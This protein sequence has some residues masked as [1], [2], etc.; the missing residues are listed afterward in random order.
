M[1]NL[2][3]TLR[4]GTIFMMQKQKGFTLLELVVV[5]VLI[6]IVS[7]AAAPSFQRWRQQQRFETDTQ[8]VLL[9]L[10]DARADSLSDKMCDGGTATAWNVLIN[11]TQITY[12]CAQVDGNSVVISVLP[13]T[14][15]AILTSQESENRTT[16]SAAGS[17]QISVFS[18]GMN[19][20][21]GSTYQ[22]QW[23]K[24]SLASSA[25]GK[26]QTVCYS[27]IANYPFLSPSGL[28]TED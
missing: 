10:A 8:N 15:D 19:A 9:A 7:G 27:R 16:W 6:G 22:S 26:E 12:G 4:T 25:L 17:L 21:I 3:P 23:A 2:P 20:R 24:V 1:T 13:L 11:E 5:I 28:C 14:S 18:G